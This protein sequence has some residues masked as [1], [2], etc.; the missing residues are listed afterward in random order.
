M[1]SLWLDSTPRIASLTASRPS[2]ILRLPLM[3]R[4]HT[5]FIGINESSPQAR[6]TSIDDAGRVVEGKVGSF[7]PKG[8]VAQLAWMVEALRSRQP[9]VAAFGVALPGLVNR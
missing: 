1:C 9:T 7:T 3:S 4:P 6:A 5:N 2:T 8:V